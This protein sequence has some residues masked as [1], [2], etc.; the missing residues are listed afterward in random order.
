MESGQ[1]VSFD[2]QRDA[3]GDDRTRRIIV[4]LLAAILVILAGW[5]LRAASSVAV[6]FVAAIFIALAVAPVDSWVRRK[7]PSR[8]SWVGHAAAM[9]LVLVV[10]A[11]FFSGVYLAAKQ[12]AEN[13]PDVSAE[14]RT[15]ISSGTESGDES[16]PDVIR[17]PP[18]DGAGGTE[19][20][21]HDDTPAAGLLG[22]EIDVRALSKR[23]GTYLVRHASDYSQTVLLTATS[24]MGGLTL[25]FFLVLLMLVEG[26]S[27][28]DKVLNAF[29]RSKA[30]GWENAVAVMAKSFR[31]YIVVRTVLGLATAALYVV[32]L[33]IFGVDLLVVWAVLTFLLSYI[34]TL[35][36]IVAGILP[37][38]YALAT[39]DWTT[40]LF[41]AA[42]ILVIEQVMGNFVDPRL[43]GKELSV[44]SLVTFF[45]LLL[46]AWLWG[47]VGALLAV[48]LAVFIVVACA[49][50]P[51]LQSVG[52]LLSNCRSMEAL[53][54]KRRADEQQANRRSVCL[55]LAGFSW[56][57]V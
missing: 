15:A 9:A 31:W 49:N 21:A 11:A 43:L 7:I 51:S 47:V 22:L 48:P 3:N 55:A 50:I 16:G 27:W 30:E 13:L 6:P 28:R 37:I 8:L 29:G 41:V 54:E 57:L 4:W 12:A 10:L 40:A 5:A 52:L 42:G 56:P 32:W 19:A 45:A 14:L 44:S 20:Q 38:A 24:F 1:A 17:L 53:Q 36:S 26:P 18:Q 23:A 39:K 35:G 34:P 25:I 46:F 33:G 2:R